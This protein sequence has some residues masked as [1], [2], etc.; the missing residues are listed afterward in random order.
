MQNPVICLS[1]HDSYR[2]VLSGITNAAKQY[3]KLKILSATEKG[4]TDEARNAY[5]KLTGLKEQRRIFETSKIPMVVSTSSFR[6]YT[7][8]KY[9]VNYY[10][11]EIDA[12]VSDV[13]DSKKQ[14]VYRKHT[15]N[16]TKSHR[17][18]GKSS[19]AIIEDVRSFINKRFGYRDYKS[20]YD[21]RDSIY[22]HYFRS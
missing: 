6:G 14:I 3:R 8:R 16:L 5:L 9:R 20:W 22:R 21:L 12:I 1:D 2:K 13:F 19:A 15:L 4:Y 7:G 11:P 18:T 10:I 17:C